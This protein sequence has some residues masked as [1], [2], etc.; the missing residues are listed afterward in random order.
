MF[1]RALVVAVTASLLALACGTPA[2]NVL[3][4]SSTRRSIDA[5]ATSPA[6]PRSGDVS[7]LAGQTPVNVCHRTAGAN[8]FILIAIPA[9]A[10][11]AHLNHGDGRVGYPVPDHPDMRFGPDCAQVPMTSLTITF[12]GLTVQGAPVSS[13]VESG[14]TV[15]PTAASWE[16]L[17]FYGHPAPSIVF[18]NPCGESTTGQVA[19]TNGGAPF[20]F[21]AVDL[22]SSVTPIPYVFAGTLNAAPVFTVTGTQPNTYGNFVMVANTH[23]SDLIDRLVITLTNTVGTYPGCGPNPMGL[24]NVVV[25]H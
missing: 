9:P 17:S 5:T 22:Y 19:M 8:A 1:S 20:R 2:D 14:F 3:E 18:K 24:D 15:L 21:V 13:Y 11:A 25:I 4:P 6:T 10:L 12:N 23:S 16:A 7:T